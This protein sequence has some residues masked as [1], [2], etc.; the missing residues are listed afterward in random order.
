MYIHCRTGSAREQS[1]WTWRANPCLPSATSVMT[2]FCVHLV[3]H[4]Q[5]QRYCRKV[6]AKQLLGTASNTVRHAG[7]TARPSQYKTLPLPPLLQIVRTVRRVGSVLYGIRPLWAEPPPPPPPEQY[8]A[9]PTI[10]KCQ[11]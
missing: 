6:T 2:V 10:C 7:G 5:Q 9:F 3:I 1:C 4:Q 11:A 8:L